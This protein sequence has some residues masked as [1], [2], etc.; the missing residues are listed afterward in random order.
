[1][2]KPSIVEL[3][4]HTPGDDWP[5]IPTIGPIRISIDGGEPIPMSVPIRSARAYWV[6]GENYPAQVKHQTDP[7]T[8]EL[9]II[10]VDAANWE[11]SIPKVAGAL[12]PLTRG[13]WYSHLE[14][15][16]EEG[17]ILTTHELRLPVG[18]DYTKS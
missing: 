4:H 2:S 9:P 5:G 18:L 13:Q 6:K 1:M 3:D 17:T 12:F 14:I 16:D 11:L 7:V 15:T 8:G 10:L